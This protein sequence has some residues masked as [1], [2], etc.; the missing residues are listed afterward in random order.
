MNI[1]TLLTEAGLTMDDIVKTPVFL[2]RIEDFQEM[3]VV[4]REFF[5]AEPLPP[6]STIGVAALARAKCPVEIE[7]IAMRE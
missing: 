5:V 6:R 7:A 4:Y 1:R 3:N 2:T